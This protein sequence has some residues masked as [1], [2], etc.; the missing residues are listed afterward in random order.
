MRR[1]GLAVVLILSVPLAPF[2][3]QGQQ[4]GKTARIGILFVGPARTPE[5]Q[6]AGALRG[7]FWPAMKD[8]GWV[9]GQN[10]VAERRY[11]ESTDQL[12]AAATDLVR[13]KVDVLLVGTA[14]WPS[15]SSWKLKPSPS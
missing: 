10:I 5:E 8:L 4:T 1:I 12:R 3:A 6:A 15:F 13:L 2:G 7:P 11:G 14:G 9:Y